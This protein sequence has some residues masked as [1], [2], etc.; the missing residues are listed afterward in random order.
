[1]IIEAVK[2]GKYKDVNPLLLPEALRNLNALYHK[3]VPKPVVALP[4]TWI[5]GTPRQVR[6]QKC[7]DWETFCNTMLTQSIK[8][9]T[10][11]QKQESR[12]DAWIGAELTDAANGWKKA[13]IKHN[14]LIG[15]DFDNNVDMEAILEWCRDLPYSVLLH[16][17]TKHTENTPRLRAV[18]PLSKP[19]PPEQYELAFRGFV[20]EAPGSVDACTFNCNRW[21]YFPAKWDVAAGET[22]VWCWDRNCGLPLH[23]WVVKGQAIVDSQTV[24]KATPAPFTPQPHVVPSKGI[25]PYQ[26]QLTST[27][28]ITRERMDEFFTAPRG[29]R[30][31]RILCHCAGRAK[32][33]GVVLTEADLMTLAQQLVAVDP[34]RTPRPN[35]RDEVRKALKL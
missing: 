32:A 5:E 21:N 11:A 10:F 35:L 31:F 8:H 6:E 14:T 24:A 4:L 1:M 20:A 12:C 17:T 28:L 9:S 30:L 25:K 34:K 19:L 29:G 2:S 23:E 18:M 27:D 7:G 3:P 26:L 13:N 22:L 16:T 15:L 33:K